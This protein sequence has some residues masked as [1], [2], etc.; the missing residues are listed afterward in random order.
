LKTSVN[1]AS[2]KQRERFLKMTLDCIK[3]QNTKPDVINVYL[4][5]YD[6]VPEFCKGVNAV[7][8]KD[9]AGDLKASGKFYFIDDWDG[10]YITCDDDLFYPKDYVGYIKDLLNQNNYDSVVGFHGTKYKS[11]PVKSYYHDQKYK[12][13]YAS[14][15]YPNANVDMLGTGTMGMHTKLGVKLSLFEYPNMCDPQLMK[16]LVENNIPQLCL[17]RAENYIHDHVGSQEGKCIW[18]DV[19]YG[20][21]AIQT[22]IVNS[23]KNYEY[24]V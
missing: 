1:I 6:S 4:N 24:Y 22:E 12:Y 7:L 23:I 16:Y 18:K 17:S 20:N 8:G 13:H 14:G 15:V 3:A 5:D 19:A 2:H 11:F 10:V 9:A 21:D